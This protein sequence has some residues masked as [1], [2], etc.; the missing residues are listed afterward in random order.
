MKV[1]VVKHN[2]DWAEEFEKESE[3]LLM[4]LGK[5]INKIYHIGSTSVPDLMAKPI[6]DILLEVPDLAALDQQASIFQNLGY[7][8]MGSFGIP[9]RRY[10][11]K[12]DQNRTH[13]L[14]AFQCGDD[15]LIRHLAFKEYLIHHPA[16]AE[17]YGQLKLD[18]ANRIKDDISTYSD[19]KAPFIKHHEKIAIEW[20]EKNLQK[21]ND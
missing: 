2:P 6:I 11:R 1:S 21:E 7:E 15:H 9:G 10:F 5:G 8:V 14:H 16:I 17:E 13:H 19:E 12:G 18:I 20:Y 3:K 4:A